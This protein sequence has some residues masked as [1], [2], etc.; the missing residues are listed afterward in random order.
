MIFVLH[1]LRKKKEFPSWIKYGWA[2]EE[3][4]QKQILDKLDAGFNCIKMKLEQLILK[5]N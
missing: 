5:L 4:M 2:T 3:F 1:F